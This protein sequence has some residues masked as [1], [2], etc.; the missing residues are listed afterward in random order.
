[1][2]S[3]CR[4]NHEAIVSTTLNQVAANA[5]VAEQEFNLKASLDQSLILRHLFT[6]NAMDVDFDC[7]ILILIRMDSVDLVSSCVVPLRFQGIQVFF[8][9]I[10]RKCWV[11]CEVFSREILSELMGWPLKLGFVIHG[12]NPLTLTTIIF[13]LA[14]TGVDPRHF[15]WS[16]RTGQFFR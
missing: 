4:D 16:G 10:S 11:E 6:S 12:Q 7:Q 5:K 1:M 9:P 2:E 8:F 3:V 15:S 14:H 13:G